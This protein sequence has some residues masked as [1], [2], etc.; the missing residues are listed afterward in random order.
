MRAGH[1]AQVTLDLVVQEQQPG[2]GGD[3]TRGAAERID[4]RRASSPAPPPPRHW[5]PGLQRGS[6]GT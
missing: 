3:G 5:R 4:G 1:L 2:T 6:T